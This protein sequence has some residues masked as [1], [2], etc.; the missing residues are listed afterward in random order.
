MIIKGREK[1]DGL[2]PDLVRVIQRLSL[3]ID[4]AI[5]EGLRTLDR[6]R[7]LVA[8]GASRTLNSRHLKA[9]NGYGHALDIYPVVSGKVIVDWA[10]GSRNADLKA[11]GAFTRL[12]TALKAAAKAEGVKIETGY[13]W[14]W[15]GP[16][17][18]LPWREYDGNG[19]PDEIAHLPRMV[20]AGVEGVKE[21]RFSEKRTTK[22][23]AIAL[24]TGAAQTT[25]TAVADAGNHF[26]TGTI[27]GYTLGVLI[28]GA[29]ALALYAA[30]DDAGRPKPW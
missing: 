21:K 5:T 22:A 23:G 24:M 18:Q 15:D 10:G 12:N 1:L 30:W 4:F 25:Q 6:Q 27:I 13:D 14:G 19:A 7:T 28:I 26:S 29:G 8:N 2:H 20:K 3:Q 9:K 16:H 11:N 17:V